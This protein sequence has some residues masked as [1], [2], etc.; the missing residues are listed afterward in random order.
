MAQT[1]KIMTRFVMAWDLA[2]SRLHRA[3][4]RDMHYHNPWYDNRL[5]LTSCHSAK[6]LKSSKSVDTIYG[7]TKF[8]F[9]GA[10]WLAR[11]AEAKH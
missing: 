4:A 7:Y 1:H 9:C 2:W 8:E 10:S 6:S 11:G 3:D 5:R